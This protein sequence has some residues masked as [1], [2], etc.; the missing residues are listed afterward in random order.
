M[1]LE[2]DIMR[3]VTHLLPVTPYAACNAL[4][5]KA[6]LAKGESRCLC[7]KTKERARHK[8]AIG[9]TTKRE[10]SAEER[11]E[12]KGGY[13]GL[14]FRFIK[15]TGLLQKIATYRQIKMFIGG[16]GGHTPTGRAH[17]KTGLDKEGFIHILQGV[18]FFTDRS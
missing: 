11:P 7:R 4:Q 3:A 13:S 6:L 9:N 2:N 16:G 1:W 18:F 5:H 8:N 10:K 14:A 12:G 17:K 15:E